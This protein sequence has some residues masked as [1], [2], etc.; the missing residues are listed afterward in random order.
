MQA[1]HASFVDDLAQSSDALVQVKTT[2]A[3]ACCAQLLFVVLSAS[4]VSD[5]HSVVARSER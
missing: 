1:K 2:H 3:K 5:L 4:A